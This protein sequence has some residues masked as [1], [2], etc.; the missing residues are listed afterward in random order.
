MLLAFYACIIPQFWVDLQFSL[1]KGLFLHQ[2]SS[3]AH[4]SFDSEHRQYLRSILKFMTQE[5]VIFKPFSQTILPQSPHAKSCVEYRA[6][7]SKQSLSIRRRDRSTMPVIWWA[8]P[9]R[10]DGKY[11]EKCNFHGAHQGQVLLRRSQSLLQI[12]KLSTRIFTKDRGTRVSLKA[13]K[14]L[15]FSVRGVADLCRMLTGSVESGKCL[16]GVSSRNCSRY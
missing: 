12:W 7:S 3:T 6:D 4:F 14:H 9:T 5:Y 15:W 1:L 10:W 13:I 8:V 16:N 11:L 2:W